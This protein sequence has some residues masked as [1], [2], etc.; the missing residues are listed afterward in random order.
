M[1]TLLLCA[2]AALAS[3][4]CA[5]TATMPVSGEF[6]DEEFET[7]H[8]DVDFGST[9]FTG[10]VD[11]AIAAGT[12]STGL[13][14][15]LVN[16]N[17][18]AMNGTSAMSVDNGSDAGTGT[19]NLSLPLTNVT[20]MQEFIVVA[21][22][23]NPGIGTYS[24]T[25]TI[26]GLTPGSIMTHGS[27]KQGGGVSRIFHRALRGT[28]TVT[29][30][31]VIEFMVNYGM[32]SQ[33][34]HVWLQAEATSDATVT[35]EA[36]IAGSPVAVDSVSGLG[37][38]SDESNSMTAMYSGMVRFRLTIAAASATVDWTALFGHMTPVAPLPF[39]QFSGSASDTT[40]R[41]HH[42]RVD[43]G[44][45]TVQTLMRVAVT[46]GSALGTEFTVTDRDSQA[47]VGNGV[48]YGGGSDD[49]THYATLFLPAYTG[50]RDFV[51]SIAPFGTGS[52]DYAAVVDVPGVEQTAVSLVAAR[53]DNN[54]LEVVFGMAAESEV[55]LATAGTRVQ[56]FRVDFGAMTHTA[57]LWFLA[58]CN[59]SGS[60]TLDELDAN[61]NPIN[62]ATANFGAIGPVTF[63]DT[64]GSRSGVVR[65]RVTSTGT[66]A[67][68]FFWVVLFDSSVTVQSP[69]SGGGDDEEEESCSTGTSQSGWLLLLLLLAL[70]TALRRTSARGRA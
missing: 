69:N 12:A 24:G 52:V 19:I 13:T 41:R 59:A 50:V 5:Q 28:S 17:E 54:G 39:A 20:G 33:D 26:V 8:F 11:L 10:T 36:I 57:D 46:A 1:K 18:L 15:S 61:G 30:T 48:A 21:E 56:E 31:R 49:L 42:V 62:L 22:G 45:G 51:V 32:M 29:G 34:T 70:P 44:A 43:F 64:T 7:T 37:A 14:A 9:P 66:G 63:N 25:L 27:E 67:A 55:S 47:S 60:V 38:F 58:E 6:H 4:L 53:N 65:F 3:C 35:L 40:P 23:M 16:P 68:D 2:F